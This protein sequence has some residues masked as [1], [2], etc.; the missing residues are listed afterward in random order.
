MRRFAMT[1]SLGSWLHCWQL[2]RLWPD[3]FKVVLKPVSIVMQQHVLLV[4]IIMQQHM[5]FRYCLFTLPSRVSPSGRR[6]PDHHD[7]TF[8]LLVI[9]FLV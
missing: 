1:G 6:R 3:S 7:H 9:D 5:H 8:F 2:Q 4:Q